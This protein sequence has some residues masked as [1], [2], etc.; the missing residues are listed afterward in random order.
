MSK[1]Y[2]KVSTFVGFNGQSVW[3]QEGDEYDDGD[4]IV[5]ANQG[6]FT[7]PEPKRPIGRPL[8]SR[9]KDG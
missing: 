9:S 7:D 4:P 1:V 6:Q 8:S 2:A 3:L 5:R